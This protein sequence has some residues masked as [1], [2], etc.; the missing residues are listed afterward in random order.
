[1]KKLIIVCG[2]PGSGKS[3]LAEVVSIE[4]SA[5]VFS[6]DPIESSI[7]K[8]GIKKSFET[9]LAAYVIAETL[10]DEQLKLGHSVIIDAVSGV[11]E[12]KEMWRKLAEKHNLKLI[13][14]ECVCSDS[15]LHKK[16]IETRV[17]NIHGIPEVT[18]EDVGK[19]REEYVAWGEE[20]LTLD[21]IR[22]TDELCRQALEY[23]RKTEA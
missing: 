8:A 14:V 7:L 15:K 23:I 21:S 5:P 18:W 3:S 17:R 12:A 10:A 19:R 20:H 4:V 6:V 1:M 11:I 22:P 16:R 9:G 13:I 2:L